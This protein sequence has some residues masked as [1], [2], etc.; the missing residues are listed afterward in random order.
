MATYFPNITDYIPK[1]QPF[2]PDF[3][4]YEKALSVKEADYKAGHDKISNL[5]GTLLNAEL[6]REPNKEKRDKF[7]QQ[8][9]NDIQRMSTVDLS[10]EENVST[11][12]Q[13]FQP[14]I[15]D[16]NISRDM[17]WTKNYRNQQQRGQQLRNCVDEKTCGGLKG[18]DKGDQA[19]NYMAEEFARSDDQGAMEMASPRYT[20]YVDTQK[21]AMEMAKSLGFE[22]Q[23][24]SLDKSGAW[25]VTSKNGSIMQGPL[26]DYFVGAFANDPTVKGV[27][28][29]QAY[30]ERKDF[31]KYRAQE[32]G[33]EEQA[34]RFYLQNTIDQIKREQDALVRAA[35]GDIDVITSTRE[36]I[37]NTIKDKGIGE[38]DK[39]GM[40]ESFNNLLEQ[41]QGKTAAKE[42]YESTAA[43]ADKKN[44][45]GADL[46]TMRWMADKA[47]SG[48]LFSRDMTEA[49]INYSTLTAKE[50]YKVNEYAMAGYKHKLDLQKMEYQHLYNIDRDKANNQAKFILE[51]YKDKTGGKS[52]DPRTDNWE[53]APQTAGNTQDI[54]L[55]AVNQEELDIQMG[56]S[57]SIYDRYYKESLD[58]YEAASKN[59]SLKNWALSQK[60]YLETLTGTDYRTNY[61]KL[62]ALNSNKNNVYLIN[63]DNIAYNNKFREMEKAYSDQEEL[64]V[65]DENIINSNRKRVALYQADQGKVNGNI[66]ADA[67]LLVDDKGRWAGPVAFAQK[68]TAKHP[69]ETYDLDTYDEVN[70]EFIALSNGNVVP[71]VESLIGNVGG[72][73]VHAIPIRIKAD[74]AAYNSTGQRV[75]MDAY[76]DFRNNITN[77]Q[78]K[79]LPGSG[80]TADEYA[81]D[82]DEVSKKSLE[83][84]FQQMEKP[85][86][87]T[88]ENR[89]V[90]D[91]IFNG[92]AANDRN[93]IGM[94]IIVD[95]Q[96]IKKNAGTA[97][98]KGLTYDLQENNVLTMYIPR[99]DARN[100][101]QI[102]ARSR[103]D[104]MLKTG[105]NIDE[106]QNGGG[107]LVLKGEPGGDATLSG[108][109]D[110]IDDYGKIRQATFTKT[111]IPQNTESAVAYARYF[112][113]ENQ[114]YNQG[115]IKQQPTT[116]YNDWYKTVSQ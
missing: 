56:S 38:N 11:A 39:N 43:H 40:S 57:K 78:L 49:A 83:F 68:W 27:Y 100:L 62:Q 97:K 41:I 37:V 33:G 74:P 113:K 61:T 79:V 105:I 70:K 13:V 92:V 12:Y 52:L 14:L 99:K 32:F 77:P 23:D 48:A 102:G 94:S 28:D 76:E 87:Y 106:F 98:N 110:I 73:V 54:N 60:K 90:A 4:F 109:L 34:E 42:Q 46:K 114:K 20:P 18:W 16:K 69:G 35:Q 104:S 66:H 10:L 36:A 95:P 58:Y 111:F 85:T 101:S 64:V 8:V 89:P 86:K 91:I 72:G 30:V 47:V 26:R 44:Y 67:D 25:I 115:I 51:E 80:H 22:M 53:K 103:Y 31:A 3:N 55:T 45:L 116:S 2:K 63:Q 88:N 112:L 59:P 7:F 81:R 107:K 6:L 96:Y 93:L 1:I 19:L 75:V 84:I 50:D 5:Y 108:N 65:Q 24:V 71:G 82:T 29:T 17:A 9:Q 15:N 21:K